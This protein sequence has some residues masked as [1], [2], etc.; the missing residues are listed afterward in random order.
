MKN[1]ERHTKTEV[2]SRARKCH[3]LRYETSPSIRQEDWIQY[4]HDHYGDR[5]ELQYTQYW[6]KAK[7]MNDNLWQNQLQGLV[8]PA[9]VELRELLQSDNLQVRQRAIDQIMKYS[10]NDVQK[11]LLKGQVEITEVLFGTP[12]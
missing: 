1:I 11:V 10:G 4:C 5:S 2:E 3:E 12:Q 9:V 7:E 6:M 8:G